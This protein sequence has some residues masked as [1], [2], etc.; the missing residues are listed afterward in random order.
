MGFL[1]RLAAAEKNFFMPYT[2]KANTD[3]K[4]WPA[5]IK[6]LFIAFQSRLA[7]SFIL[8]ELFFLNI[9][10]FALTVL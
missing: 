4:N 7:I 9:N 6:N 8:K 5:K 1:N 10:F 3:E 2:I